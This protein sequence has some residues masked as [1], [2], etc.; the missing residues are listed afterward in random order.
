MS[1]GLW[2][3]DTTYSVGPGGDFEFGDNLEYSHAPLDIKFSLTVAHHLQVDFPPGADHLALEPEGGWMPWL[4]RGSRPE[5]IRRDQPFR[6][7]SSG[8]VKM[9]VECQYLITSN[10]A[11]ANRAGQRVPVETRIT[12]PSGMYLLTGGPVSKQRLHTI[13]ELT[14]ISDQ[15]VANQPAEMHFEVGASD[16]E[17]MLRY[18]DTTFKGNVTVVWDSFLMP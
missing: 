6:F 1:A 11:I 2:E 10:C 5:T 18:P 9:R 16:V 14:A 8:P 13:D 17:T 15:Y 12:L 4:A 7:T 3:G